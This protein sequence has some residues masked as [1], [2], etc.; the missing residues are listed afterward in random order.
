MSNRAGVPSLAWPPSPTGIG[1]AAALVATALALGLQQLYAAGIIGMTAAFT[2]GAALALAHFA[3]VL[4]VVLRTRS[5][6]WAAYL[7]LT[8]LGFVSISAVTP[9]SAAV[10]LLRLSLKG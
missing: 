10:L 9:I 6:V 3:I 4:A 1:L 7:V 8:V 5:R 2:I